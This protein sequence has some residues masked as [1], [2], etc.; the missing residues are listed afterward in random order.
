MLLSS[1][2][3]FMPDALLIICLVRAFVRLRLLDIV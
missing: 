2:D 1:A 3:G